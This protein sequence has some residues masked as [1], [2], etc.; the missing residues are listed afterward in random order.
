MTRK[1]IM[2]AASRTPNP[3][4][5]APKYTTLFYFHQVQHVTYFRFIIFNTILFCYL[6]YSHSTGTTQW[7]DPRLAQVKKATVD[8]CDDD[9]KFATAIYLIFILFFFQI[10]V[11]YVPSVVK[12]FNL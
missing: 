10:S 5:F 12:P 7:V 8:E 2:I 11:V 3:Y 1:I 9:G 4:P 6:R